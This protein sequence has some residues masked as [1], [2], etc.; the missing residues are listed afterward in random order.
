MLGAVVLVSFAGVG[1]AQE[2]AIVVEPVQL[3]VR[4]KPTIEGVETFQQ[5][6]L[7]LQ[8]AV[9]VPGKPILAVDADKSRI[10][11]FVD[12]VG[13]DLKKGA[14]TGFFSWVSLVSA[15][16]D[17][18]T[19]TALLDVKTETLP[20]GK[21]TR[22]EL[23][24]VVAIVSAKGTEQK[25]QKVALQKGSKITCGP[26]PMAIGDVE[27]VQFG[28]SVVSVGITS[29]QSMDAVKAVQFLD[30]DGKQMAA[31]AMG[32]SSFGFAGSKTFTKTFGLPKKLAEFT[33]RIV[34]HANMETIEVPVKLSIGVGL[35]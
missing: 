31:Q 3:T 8:L 33:V 15:F 13:T 32:E 2:A 24:A 20:A 26:V 16:R 11:T 22:I 5:P 4:R 27:D 6:G 35:R 21:A 7:E 10:V 14:P 29:S 9:K 19:E 30:A 1:V 12:D 17:E 28:D 18:P 25:S 23:D 34:S